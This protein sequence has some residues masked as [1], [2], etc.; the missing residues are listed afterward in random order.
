MKRG[1]VNP[2][3]LE[4]RAKLAFD[5]VELEK[6]TVGELLTEKTQEVIEAMAKYPKL[7]GEAAE[8]EM[9]RE[10][11][12]ENFWKKIK[13]VNELNDGK[14]MVENSKNLKNQF[15]WSGAAQNVDPLTLH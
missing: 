8:Y 3:L 9:T 11:V 1:I 2:D 13:I 7:N 14:W 5:Q 4:E 10:E 15:G 6:F 12:I